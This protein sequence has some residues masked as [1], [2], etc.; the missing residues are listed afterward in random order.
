MGAA[1]L[2]EGNDLY[3]ALFG[4]HTVIGGA[5]GFITI[6]QNYTNDEAV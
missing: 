6:S 5:P 1:T 4:V 3:K 2:Q